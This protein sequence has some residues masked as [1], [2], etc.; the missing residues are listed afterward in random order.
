MAK[1]SGIYLWYC[2][3]EKKVYIGRAVDLNRRFSQF[4]N[5]SQRYLTIWING[6]KRVYL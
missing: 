6:I 2:I 1:Q 3:P 4:I 5:F